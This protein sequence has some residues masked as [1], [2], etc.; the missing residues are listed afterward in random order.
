MN[1]ASIKKSVVRILGPGGETLG[2]GFVV[3]AD[4]YVVTCWH[5][6]EGM[7]GLSVQPEG[8]R[9]WVDATVRPELSDPAADIAVLHA[10]EV[11]D[12]RP[13]R[14]GRTWSAKDGVWSY[15]YQ[16]QALVGSGYPVIGQI[17]GDTV[18]DGRPYIVIADADVQRGTSGAPVLDMETGRVVGVV[19][20]RIGD[21]GVA[22]ATPIERVAVHWPA[23]RQALTQSSGQLRS[24][25]A[26]LFT[27]MGYQ[28]RSLTPDNVGGFPA[29]SADLRVGPVDLRVLVALVDADEG[30]GSAAL[31]GAVYAV[32][33][34]LAERRYDKGFLVTDDA[35]VIP[36]VRETAAAQH[37]TLFT[38][39][40]LEQSLVDF[41]GYLE[42]VVHDFESFDELDENGFH[43]VID[44]FRWCDLYRYYVDL[45]CT[46]LLTGRE[47]AGAIGMLREFL[48][49]SDRNLLSILGDYGTGKTSLCLQLTYELSRQCLRDP[50]GTRVP[51]FV[52]HRDFDHRQGFR[53]L[54]LE[55]VNRYG[56]Q[57]ADYRAV[58]LMLRAGRLVLIFDGFDEVADGLD[59][60]EVTQLFGQIS[61]LLTGR[62][63]V[64][65]TCRTH[66]FRSEHQSLETLTT[67]AMTP[68]MREVR[69]RHGFGIVEL[70]KLS[71]AQ[72]LDLM[73][74]RDPDYR[75]RWQYMNG[76]YNLADLARTP[77]LLNIILS[78]FQDLISLG[79]ETPI[80]ASQLYDMYTKFWLE[81]DDERSDITAHERLAFA[82]ALAWRMYTTDRLVIP[83]EELSTAVDEFFSGPYMRDRQRFNK[84][85]NNVRTC[86]FLARDRF[87]NFMFAHKSFMEFFVAKRLAADVPGWPTLDLG[88]QVVPYEIGDFVTQMVS[89]DDVRTIKAL[90]LDRENN[91]IVRGLC[92]D[93]LIARGDTVRD[94]PLVFAMVATPD[95]RL[96]TANANGTATVLTERLEVVTTL[97]GHEDWI[98][99]VTISPDGTMLATCGWDGRVTLWRLPDLV[100]SGT[101][102]FSE[103]VNSVCFD[104]QSELLLCAGYD[105]QITVLDAGAM[106]P[107]FALSGHV[108][109]VN[110]IIASPVGDTVVSA[111]LDKTLRIWSLGKPDRPT[112]IVQVDE[113]TTRMAFAPDGLSFASGSWAGEVTLWDPA[114]VAPRWSSRKHA[115]MI[116]AVGFSPDG[117]FLA[118]SSDDRT[119][120]I[121]RARTG[122]SVT[123][124][125][126][127]DFVTAVCFGRRDHHF[128][129]AGYDSQVHMYDMATWRLLATTD[130][131]GA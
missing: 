33:S 69:S 35:D 84:L 122:E 7:S 57:V 96:V 95:D 131:R 92:M 2:T 16:Y 123:T 114:T 110:A 107:V 91:D 80:N 126:H 67:E 77:I 121:W 3:L 30:S 37:V 38:V 106:R 66:Y 6:I 112:A 90:A 9:R 113:P 118:S 45:R 79:A 27:A 76:V 23:L 108:G 47:H 115:N 18:R 28:V 102:Q 65:L 51:V 62:A 40:D 75:Q 24:R 11:A 99:Q 103:R 21:R 5:V 88:A 117:E 128:Y 31:R 82:Q 20:A 89:L 120:R 111:G 13:V 86:S 56:V 63:K 26:D 87:G 85:D 64:V 101:F 42:A 34:Q 15:G 55:A 125:P 19:H 10:P 73:S 116:G 98:R 39:V 54:V 72:I 22:L 46:D 17:S 130:L 68:L 48:S 1:T 78:S 124:L 127:S 25:V 81:R 4:G 36:A 104:R 58:E 49:A 14:T 59:R 129:C 12:L 94:E 83:S 52:P 43:P 100:R 71:E 97:D 74:R 93:V 119:A 8:D 32:G 70:R 105:R 50:A 53:R 29:F 61:Q 41:T 60:R 44:H 109:G